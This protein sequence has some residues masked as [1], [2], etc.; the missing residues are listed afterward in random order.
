MLLYLPEKVDR[1]VESIN[2][3][4]LAADMCAV[5]GRKA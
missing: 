4:T 1:Y 2:D 5:P 3:R